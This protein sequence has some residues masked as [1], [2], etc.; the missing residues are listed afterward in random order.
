MEVHDEVDDLKG[1]VTPDGVDNELLAVV[2]Y[3]VRTVGVVQALVGLLVV[4]SPLVEVLDRLLRVRALVVWGVELDSANILSEELGVL[5]DG[6]D[7]GWVKRG[8]D[9]MVV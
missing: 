4:L 8:P 1:E 9:G 2:D 3:H 5:T 6:L 7:A